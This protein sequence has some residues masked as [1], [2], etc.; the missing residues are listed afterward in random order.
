MAKQ[1]CLFNVKVFLSTAGEGREIMCFR[2]GQPIFTEGDRS[3]ALFIIQTGLVRLSA[4]SHGGKEA[5]I[6]ILDCGDFV[7]KDS[8]AG[9]PTRTTS[10]SALTA[11]QLLR[12]E[13]K[14]MMV[15]LAQEVALS[16]SFCASVLAR[17]IQYQQDLVD[18]RCNS[19]EKRLAHILLRL[20]HLDEQSLPEV[21][22]SR[23]GHETLANMV[24]TTRSRACFFMKK[25]K[26]AG[27][28]DYG[29]KTGLLVRR[30]LLHFYAR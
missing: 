19:S 16:N 23:I 20:S 1:D 25:F 15:A 10:A 3:D 18:Q 30:S 27:F 14:A 12:I 11:C 7:G 9:Q 8:V 28:I 2:K 26:D 29:P 24:G 5:T 6:D 17:N 21:T 13:K 4:R 22:V